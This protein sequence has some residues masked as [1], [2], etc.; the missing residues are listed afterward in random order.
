MGASQSSSSS[1]VTAPVVVAGMG[2]DQDIEGGSFN[3]RVGSALI[4]AGPD[5]GRDKVFD[6]RLKEGIAEH[7]GERMDVSNIEGI[8]GVVTDEGVVETDTSVGEEVDY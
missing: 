3:D 1:G 4:K 6:V 2:I 5:R 7:A 8:V